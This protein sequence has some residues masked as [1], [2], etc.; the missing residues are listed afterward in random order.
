MDV[1]TTRSRD[2]LSRLR[3]GAVR[4]FR[5]VSAGEGGFTL[6]E[7]L[8]AMSLLL[9][10]ST[11]LV[12][13]MTTGIVTN[14]FSR[15]RTL[16]EQLT[17]QKVEQIRGMTY[18]QVGT[19]N[20]NPPGT[21]STPDHLNLA[22]G[23]SGAGDAATLTTQVAYVNDPTPTG[24][25]SEAN[26]KKVTL[27]ITRDKD[28]KQLAKEVTYI[29]PPGDGTFTPKGKGIIGAQLQDFV[30]HS[31]ITGV[32]VDLG[33]GPSAPRTDIS[34]ANGKVSFPQLTP[35]PGS[36]AQ[37]YYDLTIPASAGWST[38][39]APPATTAHTAITA[40]STW[41]TVL[42]L[43]K[44]S[45]ITATLVDST[46]PSAVPSG[47]QVTL[48]T[49]PSAT[50]TAT[51]SSSGVASFSG[52][53]PTEASGAQAFYDL[54]LPAAWTVET[55]DATP[56]A[57]A[58]FSLGEAQSKST[59]LHVYKPGSITV[60]VKNG[61]STY[62]SGTSTITVAGP[63]TT[64]TYTTTNG[65]LTLTQFAGEPLRPNKTYT[66]SGWINNGSVKFAPAVA[67]LVPLTGYPGTTAQSYQLNLNMNTYTTRTFSVKVLKSGVVQ[68]GAR[69][70]L[71]G[72]P[73]TPGSILLS[74]TTN[75]SGL[76][77]FTVPDSGAT[78]SYTA[79]A[80][81]TTA[82]GSAGPFTVTGTT[83]PTQTVNVS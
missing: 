33:T 16:A 39:D 67:S 40:N 52:I 19:A 21:I 74:G 8:M 59:T 58:H 31:P 64:A 82:T 36:G 23:S 51:T 14:R 24:F 66:I 54:T 56:A 47:V 7:M 46:K 12:T 72:G 22:G 79:T 28:G 25:Q 65:V 73:A 29:T 48:G 80:S 6:I 78:A 37:A 42:R 75:S 9:I 2:K 70:D 26:Y 18:D 11:P 81:T 69:V 34:D 3:I 38:L 71:T 17:A 15:E 55:T 43:F 57:P 44:P 13:V 1:L 4:R 50:Q 83:P 5:R 27:A 41:P 68:N 60:T 20:G 45:T 76:V 10:V 32:E 77:S 49:G 35:N 30:T 53:A 61:A 62:T 63:T